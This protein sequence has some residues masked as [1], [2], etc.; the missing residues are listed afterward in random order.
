MNQTLKL[1]YPN[2]Q[3]AAPGG[4]MIEEV[5]VRRPNA[6]EVLEVISD[7]DLTP[8]QKDT[9]LLAKLTGI[10]PEDLKKLDWEDYQGL[11]LILGDLMSPPESRDSEE[12]RNSKPD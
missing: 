7:R 6:G 3:V 9:N 12:S 4:R 10:N 8:A 5:T 1:K 11:T 2:K